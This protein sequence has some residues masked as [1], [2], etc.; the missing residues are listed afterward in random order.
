MYIKIYE[1]ICVIIQTVQSTI[2]ITSFIVYNGNIAIVNLL[3]TLGVW[4]MCVE[5]PSFSRWIEILMYIYVYRYQ[6]DRHNFCGGIFFAL[7]ACT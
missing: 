7:I 2:D 6:K 4:L 5:R 3:C 1:S